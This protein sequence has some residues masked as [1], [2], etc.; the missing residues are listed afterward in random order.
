M[1]TPG[2]ML[3]NVPNEEVGMRLALTGALPMP[4]NQLTAL[5]LSSCSV[6]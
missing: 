4:A 1:D 2:V 5:L 3:P 6:E